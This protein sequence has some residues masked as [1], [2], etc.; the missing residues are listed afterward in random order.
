MKMNH[1]EMPSMAQA[2][3]SMIKMVMVLRTMFRRLIKNLID[4]IYQTTSSQPKI[5]TIPNT[6]T[7][8]VM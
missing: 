1:G 4:S 3:L 5:S 6:V 7:F 8:Q 2:E